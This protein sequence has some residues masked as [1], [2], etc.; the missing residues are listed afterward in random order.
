L[1][2]EAEWE[3][4]CR[5]GSTTRYCFGDDEAALMEYSW[6]GGNSDD[7]PHPV[8]QMKSNA[9]GLYDLHGNVWEWCSDWYDK[10]YYPKSPT[11]DPT[12]PVTG[13]SRVNRGGG[14]HDDARNCQSWVRSRYQ[15]TSRYIILGFRVARAPSASQAVG[16]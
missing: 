10:D 15:P 2:T 5:A 4:A 3:Y 6:Y 1:P 7:R 16:E 13:S 8:A 9:W 14:W 12:G 11:A